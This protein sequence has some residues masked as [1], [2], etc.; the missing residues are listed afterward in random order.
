M[1]R[2]SDEDRAELKKLSAEDRAELVEALGLKSSSSDGDILKTVELLQERVAKLEKAPP[3]RRS[4][5]S[6]KSGDGPFA[7]LKTFFGEG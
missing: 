1:A 5:S 3:T 2:L 6:A 7:F 4:S